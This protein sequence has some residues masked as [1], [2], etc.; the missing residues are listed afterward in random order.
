M[1]SRVQ[2]IRPVFVAGTLL[3][4]LTACSVGHP[5][6]GIVGA[7][8]E[9]D[10]DSADLSLLALVQGPGLT[11][12]AS[13]TAVTE[14]YLFQA[15][16][17]S[18][19]GDLRNGQPT[20]RQG[21][22]LRCNTAPPAL[23]VS[24][25]QIRA[26]ISIDGADEIRDMPANYGVPITQPIYPPGGAALRLAANWTDLL[27]VGVPLERSLTAAG[28]GSPNDWWSFSLSNGSLSGA[29][30]INGTDSAAFPNSPGLGDD[31]ATSVDWIQAP[32]GSFC[33]TNGQL[34]CLCYTP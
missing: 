8:S 3:A 19:S 24:C 9:G 25:G 17:L 30:C 22:D 16:T 7:N 15:S 18:P 23:P 27:D 2:Y 28:L 10:S 21:A 12:A 1:A 20:A 33:N 4:V 32:F 5:L 34:L 6:V 11:A 13:P 29:N 31:T 26:M 14:I